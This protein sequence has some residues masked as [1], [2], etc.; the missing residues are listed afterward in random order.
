[1]VKIRATDMLQLAPNCFALSCVVVRFME[2]QRFRV[3]FFSAVATRS[4]Q[5]SMTVSSFQ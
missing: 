5:N 4:V 2:K 3:T 1:M